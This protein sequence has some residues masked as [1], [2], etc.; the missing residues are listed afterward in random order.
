MRGGLLVSGAALVFL[1]CFPMLG[2]TDDGGG[3][4]GAD[5][6]GADGVQ[7]YRYKKRC[8]QLRGEQAAG[9]ATY[10][11]HHEWAQLDC[12]FWT[13]RDVAGA[14]TGAYVY[15]YL[16]YAALVQRMKALADLYPSLVRLRTAQDR[17]DLPTAGMC[18][19]DMRG[20]QKAACR[21]WILEIGSE[22]RPA[23]DKPQMLLSGA[24]HGN[25]RVGPTT[26]VELAT[27]LLGRYTADP[28]I[29]MLLDTRTIVMVPAA[30]AVGYY[31]NKR[32]ELGVD[33]NRDF[34]YDT[35]QQ[36]CMRTVAARSL[37]EVWRSHI[38][39]FAVTFHGGDNLLAFPW[40]DTAHCPG[41]PRACTGAC[42]RA[43]TRASERERARARER[44]I[45]TWTER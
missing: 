16:D 11:L 15:R 33:P 29:K 9:K 36:S 18:S 12:N 24:L 22:E 32:E 26:L 4:G 45:L 38:F 40:G 2:H 13:S 31:Q 10:T 23:A 35:S 27:F 41:F 30:N 42:A 21:V 17:Y 37:N 1:C 6:V 14:E 44:E 19:E 43:R 39:S 3:A 28:W 25:E 34:A 8:E 7:R 5:G 20:I